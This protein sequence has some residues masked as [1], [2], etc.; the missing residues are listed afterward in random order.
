[1]TIIVEDGTGVEN[2]NSYNTHTELTSYAGLRGIEVPEAQ[3]DLEELLIRGMDYFESL[4]FNGEK[5]E[6]DQSL[7]FPRK[8]LYIDNIEIDKNT[9][10]SLVKESQLEISIA[11]YQGYD[12]LAVSE[13]AVKRERV[14]GAVEVE[15]MDNAASKDRAQA[16]DAKIKKLIRSGTI[17]GIFFRVDRV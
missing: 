15:Y 4:D 9:I 8:Y 3:A 6:G 11:I 2:A 12:P 16:I 1:M 5:T 17:G 7:Q 13:R 10:H 14:Y